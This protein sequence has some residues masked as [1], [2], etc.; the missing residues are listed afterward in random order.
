MRSNEEDEFEKKYGNN[1]GV[2]EYPTSW[3][4][5]AIGATRL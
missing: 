5:A 4:N 3:Q 1:Q 2:T